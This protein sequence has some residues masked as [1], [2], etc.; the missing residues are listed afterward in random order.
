MGHIINLTVQAFLFHNVINIAELE[1][2]DK[3]EKRE[4]KWKRGGHLEIPPS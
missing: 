2:Y 3:M 1:L 4:V